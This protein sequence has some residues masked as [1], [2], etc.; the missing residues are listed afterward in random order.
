MKKYTDFVLDARGN[1]LNAATVTVVNYPSGT[2]AT[3][4]SDDGT[5]AIAGGII[6][7]STTG[8]FE[9][10]A[11]PGRYSLQVRVAGALLRTI[12]DV[13]IDEGLSEEVASI[14]ALKALKGMGSLQYSVRV[15]GYHTAGDG[16]GGEFYWDSASSATDN[17]GTVIAANAGGVGRWRRVYS[18]LL[19]IRWFGAKGDGTTDDINKINTALLA[20]SALVPSGTFRTTTTIDIPAATCLIGEGVASV[21]LLDHDFRGIGMTADYACVKNLKVRG[22]GAAVSPVAGRGAI[23][24]EVADHLIIENVW[25]NDARSTGISF[26]SCDDVTLSNFI[27]D[28]TYEHGV[29]FSACTE[30]AV[31]NGVIKNAGK[32][33]GGTAGY[34]FKL[35]NCSKVVGNNVNVINADTYGVVVDATTASSK[36]GLSNFHG[37][38]RAT[39]GYAGLRIA[40]SVDDLEINGGRFQGD[41]GVS[42]TGNSGLDRPTNIR[43][44]N[45]KAVADASNGFRVIWGHNIYINGGTAAGAGGN[46][47]WLINADAETVYFNPTAQLV[48]NSTIR[49]LNTATKGIENTG[50]GTIASGTTSLAVTHLLGAAPLAENI[51]IGFTESPTNDPGNWWISNITST[52]FTLNVR[53]DPGASNLDFT[54]R[55]VN[56]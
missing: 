45:V 23:H 9:F 48:P 11:P 56:R 22:N 20:G 53:N 29:Y 43:F 5:T 28:N 1:A 34:G 3:I 15:L 24:G 33:T 31:S 19:N 14:A 13:Q 46:Y 26:G 7:T 12:S 16:G 27:V 54:W 42:L 44:N 50:T 21:I 36:I 35:S 40:A 37:Q 18:G 2:A 38:G 39:G 47:N 52:Q 51:T 41:Y 17:G 30:V 32:A 49:I 25:V 4:Y 8:L 10:Y 55:A 6:T